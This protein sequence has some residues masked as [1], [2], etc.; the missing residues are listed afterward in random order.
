[1]RIMFMGTPE[2]AST[3]LSK[4]VSDGHDVVACVTGK[5]LVA[6]GLR[7]IYGDTELATILARWLT[8]VPAVVVQSL[9]TIFKF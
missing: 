4:L 2:I 6:Q 5:G 3:C 9:T 7:C 8:D 1:M